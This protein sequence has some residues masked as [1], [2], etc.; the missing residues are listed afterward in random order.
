MKNEQ[1]E[2]QLI[3]TG[4]QTKALTQP[5]IAPDSMIEL[6]GNNRLDLTG[7]TSEQLQELKAK[8]AES[9]I[10][11]NKKAQELLVDV[12][13]LD[14]SLSTM[15]QH[16]CEVANEGQDVTITHTQDNSVGRTEV[17]MG[18]SE[19]AKRGKLTR[20]QI[21]NSDNT[22]LPWGIIALVVVAFAILVAAMN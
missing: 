2:K 15:A 17:I 19:A 16:T 14:K 6:G 11:V 9:M 4:D 18:T 3:P 7:L 12:S 21:G 8:H 13:A 10:E 5:N 1:S 20:S 22:Y